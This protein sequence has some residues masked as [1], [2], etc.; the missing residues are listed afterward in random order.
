MI[1]NILYVMFA[2][3]QGSLDLS[4]DFSYIENNI[5]LNFVYQVLD[6]NSKGMF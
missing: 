6:V 2:F 3:M 1:E 5:V 4:K